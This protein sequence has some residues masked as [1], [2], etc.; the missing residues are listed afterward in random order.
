MSIENKRKLIDVLKTKGKVFITTERNI[1]D[2]FKQYQLNLSPEKAHSLIAFST[3]LIGDS[4]TMT[5]EAAVL[6]VPSIRCNTFVDRISYLD[7]E[8]YKYDLTFGFRPE[9]SDKM[10]DKLDELLSMPNMKSEFQKKREKLLND[11]I[12]VTKFLTWFIE[13][14]PESNEIMKNNPDYQYNFK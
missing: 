3:M 9:C 5:S 12:D 13:N 6:G 8:Q 4:Q 10:F 14:Y 7:E 1:D 2:E 11:K